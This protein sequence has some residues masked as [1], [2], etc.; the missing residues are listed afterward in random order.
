MCAQNAKWLVKREGWEKRSTKMHNCSTIWAIH[1]YIRDVS[2]RQVCCYRSQMRALMRS[3]DSV[4]PLVR[5]TIIP[6]LIDRQRLL[7]DQQRPK[8]SSTHTH[9]HQSMSARHCS[10]Y[11]STF[12]T[13]K[14]V[15]CWLRH[16]ALLKWKQID[17]IS[18]TRRK[19]ANCLNMCVCVCCISKEK[20]NHRRQI[21]TQVSNISSSDSKSATSQNT[22]KIGSFKNAF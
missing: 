16:T 5:R 20:G 4:I 11:F 2:S 15:C 17:A 10:Q 19:L 1:I 14:E 9:S 6:L 8:I 22:S 3:A 12:A 21:I 18:I 13:V 7:I